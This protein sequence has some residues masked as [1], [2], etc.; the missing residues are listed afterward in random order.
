[1]EKYQQGNTGIS[2]VE[3][4]AATYDYLTGL[5]G[6]SY[7]FQLAED[8]RVKIKNDKGTPAMLFI[9]LNGMKNFNR[10]YGYGG[11]DTLIQAVAALLVQ[12]FGKESC[13]RFGGDHFVLYTRAEGLRDI[14]DSLFSDCKKINDG[15]NLPLRVGVYLEGDDHVSAATACDRAKIACDENRDTYVSH[16][17]YFSSSMLE[18]EEKR[19]YVIDNIDRAIR[20]GHI[21]VYHHPIIR[22]AN[23]YVCCEEA[24]A[25]WDD[26]ERGF[27]LPGDFIPALENAKLIYKLDLYITEKIL[28]KMKLQAERGFYVVPESVNLSRTDFDSCDIVEEIRKRVDASGIERDKLTIE[29]TES[30]VSDSFDFMK[31]QIDRF[32]ELGFRVWMDDF[33]SGYSSP[34]ILQNIPF[35]VIKLDMFFMRQF[36]EGEE[37]R[38]LLT[39]FVKLMISLGKETVV[40]GVETARQAEFLKEIGCTMLQGFYYSIPMPLE[41][42]FLQGERGN[43]LVFE[44]PAEADYYSAIGRVNLYDLSSATSADAS[45]SRYFD[46]MPMIVI[47]ADDKKIKMIRCNESY[48]RFRDRNIRL[49][50]GTDGVAFLDH[51]KGPGALFMKAV[52]KCQ[53][54]GESVVLDELTTEGAV[55]HVFIRKVSDNPVTGKSSFVVVVLGMVRDDPMNSA[56]T[57][58]YVARALSADY[59]NLFVV[60]LDDESFIEYSPNGKDGDLSIERHGEDFFETSRSDALIYLYE[61]DR[62]LFVNSFTRENVMRNIKEQG[63]FTLTYRLMIN[64]QPTYVNMKAVK[65]SVVGNRIIIGVNNVDVQMRHKEE[66]QRLNEEK[67]TYSRITALSGDYICFYT[68]DPETDRFSEY[69]ASKDYSNLKLAKD[70]DDFFNTARKASGRTVWHEDHEMFLSAFTRENILNTI[71]E[72]GVFSMMYRLMLSGEPTYVRLKAAKV[73][74]NGKLRIII[75]VNNIDSQVKRDIDYSNKLSAARDLANI[76]RLTGVKNKHAYVDLED[77]INKTIEDGRAEPFAVVVFD[78]NGLKVIN[79][80]LG[81]Q[82]GD[83]F[84]KKGCLRI[85]GIFKHSPVFRIGGDEF[86]V[87]AQGAD[88]DSIDDHMHELQE[89]NEQSLRSQDVVVAAGMSR[90]EINDRDVNSVFERADRLMYENKRGYK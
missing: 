6:I 65:V 14:L 49:L 68:V 58:T 24:L 2:F 75:G 44:N 39:E 76:D 88:Y 27:L 50:R 48:R 30:I 47:E 54:D 20:E 22:A 12:Y 17:S 74:E 46:T 41:E 40:E 79:D 52:R 72:Y 90:Y 38:V 33:G 1:M 70:G 60:N 82:E 18:K 63:S 26:P 57:Y 77:S 34:L 78:L 13:S 56:V 32:K 61:P 29:I 45:L 31:Q 87:I 86:A 59:I 21:K 80:T 71:E 89:L 53:E 67:I 28:E 73:Y 15:K 66:L 35:D 84:I 8:G 10:R 25:R 42:L 64:G 23:G 55:A 51:T 3:S 9:D 7:F 83:R 43:P 69:N 37:K 4:S 36:D 19:Q 62:D 16:Y 11:G 85:C 81:H 5:P